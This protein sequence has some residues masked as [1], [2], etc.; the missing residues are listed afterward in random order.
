MRCPNCRTQLY[1]STAPTCWKCGSERAALDPSDETACSPLR[2]LRLTLKR[3]WFDM[4]ASGEKREE[5]REPGNWIM[6]RL[7]GK[8]YDVVEFANGYGVN[9]PRV[10]CQ[11]LGWT[12]GGGRPEWGASQDRHYV[13]IR[14][15]EVISTENDQVE[16]RSE[17]APHQQ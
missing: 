17:S 7:T 16:A 9:V 15:G 5:Y 1:E 3:K 6:S 4:I 14:L 11:Y 2:V 8:D 10:T 12:R 13:V